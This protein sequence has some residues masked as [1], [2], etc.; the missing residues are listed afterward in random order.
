MKEPKEK[1]P[2]SS[3]TLLGVLWTL[4]PEGVWASP[5]PACC[6]TRDSPLRVLAEGFLFGPSSSLAAKLAGKLTF[7]C[8]WFLGE[9]DKPC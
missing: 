8:S 6:K 2:A 3:H 7:V 5:G 4:V 1:R 9:P